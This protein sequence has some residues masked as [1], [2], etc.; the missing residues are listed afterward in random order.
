M[1][2]NGQ[3]IFHAIA[4]FD[5]DTEGKRGF[6]SLTGQHL[7]YRKW[8]DV[9]LLQRVIPRTTRDPVQIA[10][11]V[12]K[13]NENWRGM[14]CEIEDLV[15][16]SL[17][18]AFIS[19]NPGSVQ[20]PLE[21]LNGAV[22]CRFHRPAK[23]TF[24]RFVEDNAMLQDLNLV[25]EALKSLRYH[26]GLQPDGEPRPRR[27]RTKNHRCLFVSRRPHL[28]LISTRQSWSDFAPLMP[29]ET[30]CQFWLQRLYNLRRDKRGTH[31]RPHKPAL[32]LSILDL[33]D[34]GQLQNN[35]VPLNDNLTK[36]FRRYF[37]IVR[38]EDDKPTIEN[39]F[40][41]LSGDGFWSL[42][43]PA[44]RQ[45]YVPGNATSP[46][47]MSILRSSPGHFD[48]ALWNLLQS[49][50][51]R[52]E[53]REAL[54]SRYFPSHRY[55]LAT[56]H[57]TPVVVEPLHLKEVFKKARDAAFR[58][59]VLDIYD[60]LCA[61]CGLRV[62]LADG[63]S[64]LDAAHL[65]P[66]EDPDSNDNPTNGLALCPNHHRAMDRSLIAPVPDPVHRA[67]IWRISP[68]VEALRDSRGELTSLAGRPVLEPTE[69]KFLP[70]EA[71]LRWRE[72]HLITK[73]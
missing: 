55:A 45:L 62:R 3:K 70:A 46:P 14:D 22:H 68:R 57:S 12:D 30:T 53:L 61:A 2:P 26:L 33:M 60:H 11:L 13:A 37:D 6:S 7:N 73:Y 25:V 41:F 4:L 1:T 44:G 72:Q 35:E 54:I 47:S 18:K 52:Q 10:Q 27:H 49:P 43:D 65:I 34:H 24:V 48:P 39:P 66:V 67:G 32:L 69:S 23:A 42:Q 8:R 5:S 59:T 19:E 36:T 64:L 58:E 21:E 63:F 16:A 9:F 28:C 20:R 40:Y 56:L 50:G 15:S 29:K 71:S 31:E 38:Q 51:T 17:I